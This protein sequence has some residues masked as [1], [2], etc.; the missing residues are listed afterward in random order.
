MV[1]DVR[2]WVIMQPTIQDLLNSICQIIINKT[3]ESYEKTRLLMTT[4]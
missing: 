4:A 1:K 3:Y 2:H